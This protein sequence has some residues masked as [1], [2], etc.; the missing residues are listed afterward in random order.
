MNGVKV[1]IQE[2]TKRIA[3]A[4]LTLVIAV[5]I[6]LLLPEESSPSNNDNNNETLVEGNQNEDNKD[7]ANVDSNDT[8]QDQNDQNKDDTNADANQDTQDKNESKEDKEDLLN[9]NVKPENIG[10]QMGNT[11][12]DDDMGIVTYEEEG[13]IIYNSVRD[14]EANLFFATDQTEHDT[15]GSILKGLKT[16]EEGGLYVNNYKEDIAFFKHAE[17]GWYVYFTNDGAPIVKLKPG[18]RISIQGTLTDGQGGKVTFLPVTFEYTGTKVWPIVSREPIVPQEK[19][20]KHITTRVIGATEGRVDRNLFFTLEEICPIGPSLPMTIWDWTE[21]GIYVDGRRV[22]VPITKWGGQYFYIYAAFDGWLTMNPVKGTRVGIQGTMTDGKNS[23]TIEPVTFEHDG[24][25]NWTVVSRDQV[26]PETDIKHE[27]QPGEKEVYLYDNYRA[28]HNLHFSS[29]SNDTVPHGNWSVLYSATTGGIYVDGVKNNGGLFMKN[30]PN[31]Y[32]VYMPHLG[33]T[34]VE[35]MRITIQG[36]FA[37]HYTRENETTY[38]PATFEFDGKGWYMVSREELDDGNPKPSEGEKEVYLY[39]DYKVDKTIWFTSSTNDTVPSDAG[40]ACLYRATTGGVYINGKKSDVPVLVKTGPNQYIVPLGGWGIN[41]E[42]GMKVTIQGAFKMDG[43][44]EEIIYHPATFEF[45]GQG[46]KLVSREEVDEDRPQPEEGEKEV[47]LYED[48]RAG[49][50]TINFTSSSNDT[51][52]HGNWSVVYSATAEGGVYINGTKKDG[53]VIMKNGENFYQLWMGHIAGYTPA[54]G[55][56]IH[57]EGT[58]TNGTETIT[59]HP[60][61]FEYDGSGWK[62]VSR[63]SIQAN[64]STRPQP[65]EGEEEVYIYEKV[66]VEDSNLSFETSSN[67]TVPHNGD[68]SVTYAAKDGGIYVNGTKNEAL[69]LVKTSA[70]GYLIY[71]PSGSVTVTEGME[72]VIQGTF[73]HGSNQITYHPVTFKYEGNTWKLISREEYRPNRPEPGEG[74]KEVYLYEDYQTDTNLHFETSSND[75]VPHAEGWSALYTATTGGVFVD[76]VRNDDFILIKVGTNNYILYMPHGGI[77]PTEGT[78][79]SI[80]GTFATMTTGT[81]V[82]TYH[83]ATFE[84]DGEGW[85]LVSREAIV[86]EVKVTLNEDYKTD[87]TLWFT[88]SSNDI[89]PHSESWQCQYEATAGGI[90]VDGV[91][92][93]DLVLVKYGAHNYLI[94]L[95]DIGVTVVKDM[96]VT[97]QGDVATVD[98]HVNKITYLSATFQY[99]GS[100]WKVVSREPIEEKTEVTISENYQADK[101]LWFTTSAE[102]TVPHKGDWTVTYA[103]KGDDG[104]FVDGTKNED[105]VLVKYGANNYLVY[106]AG[107]GMTPT[108]DMKVTIKGT[109]AT[110]GTGTDEITYKTT[111][112]QYDGTGWKVV[113]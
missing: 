13:V 98:T 85:T 63:E 74:E 104:I 1:F 92:N 102:D 22:S 14:D 27:I 90:Y 96:K 24:E 65:G 9:D 55:D 16:W 43:G 5:S 49:D 72:V 54:S 12:Y 36:T 62:L 32:M 67:D 46:W 17:N 41:P 6:V 77:T 109:F 53:V 84:Y 19:P 2:N 23:T 60:A 112:F 105:L 79:I 52:P 97:I 110:S 87:K 101:T 39:E 51:V 64:D 78:Q 47:Y 25:G 15:I 18:D 58:F 59:Y 107:I 111:T 66:G 21:G 75:T 42:E 82:I 38:H 91:K 33:I 61:T 95:Q 37:D 89:V 20:P 8:T 44:S 93:N 106:F 81:D 26:I 31:G 40:W 80:Q 100:G 76:G 30:S 69:V 57:I 50:S 94:P 29:S 113:S 28:D 11:K 48:Y 4:V 99:D 88:T 10:I 108:K 71:F 56:Q 70:N 73:E 83:P 7:D 68:W 3:L 45:D 35:G 103:G 34:P 86:E